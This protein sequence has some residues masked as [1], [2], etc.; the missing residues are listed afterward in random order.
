MDRSDALAA[1]VLRSWTPASTASGVMA[2]PGKLTLF[3]GGVRDIPVRLVD[4]GVR[5]AGRQGPR[6][7]R[8]RI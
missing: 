1:S 5:S 6:L 8:R 2:A 4:L 7:S 3:V